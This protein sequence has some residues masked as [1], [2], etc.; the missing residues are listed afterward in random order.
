MT[1]RRLPLVDAGDALLAA[2]EHAQARLDARV[3]DRLAILATD[4]R[5]V[6]CR[7]G[8]TACCFFAIEVQ[9]LDIWRI[10]PE[11]RTWSP[12]ELARLRRRLTKAMARAKAAGLNLARLQG[13]LEKRQRYAEARIPCPFLVD[14]ACTIYAARPS[15]CRTHYVVDT[16]PRECAKP[17]TAAGFWHL[18]L[19]HLVDLFFQEIVA[20]FAAARPSA[21]LFPTGA[22]GS[23]NFLLALS[24]AWELIE[25]P[26]IP[27][28]TWLR[29]PIAR[30]ALGHLADAV[31]AARRANP[32]LAGGP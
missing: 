15:A 26:E 28:E 8:C 25:H 3:T 32:H 12:A 16:D 2:T 20:G 14:S 7:K 24:S 17:R 30:A 10:V 6:P 19:G 4:G 13:S 21:T 11:L 22:F 31:D 9:L 29:R 1:R 18:D 5:N 23:L 27:L